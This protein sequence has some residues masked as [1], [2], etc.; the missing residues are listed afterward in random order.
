MKSVF[1]EVCGFNELDLPCAFSGVEF[2]LKVERL[3]YRNLWTP[4]A[5][6]Y[7]NVDDSCDAES[8]RGDVGDFDQEVSNMKHV[9]GESSIPDP[10]YDANLTLVEEDFSIGIRG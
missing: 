3:G 4:Y 1:N 2:C 7:L 8:A 5:E 9:W 6:L 10:F